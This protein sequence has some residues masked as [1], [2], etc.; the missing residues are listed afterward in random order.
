MHVSKN[1]QSVG[2][3]LQFRLKRSFA[4][5]E[6]FRFGIVFLKNR[7]SAQAR[8]NAFLRNQPARLHDSP[9][10][11]ARR[12]PIYER[13]FIERDTSAIDP[14]FFRRATQLDQ[15]VSQ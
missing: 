11:V 13:K 2:E 8:G 1:P 7:K 14:Q 12:P 9:F 3:H 4:S 15:S 5:D 10:S 6:K